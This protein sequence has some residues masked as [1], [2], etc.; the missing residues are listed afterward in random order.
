MAKDGNGEVEREKGEEQAA[1]DKAEKAGE[2]LP[3]RPEHVHP[4]EE[5]RR[6]HPNGDDPKKES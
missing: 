5:K 6:A 4:R 2:E 3:Q 1:K